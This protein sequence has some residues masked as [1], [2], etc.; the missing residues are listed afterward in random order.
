MGEGW[1]ESRTTG[2]V[3]Y[4]ALEVLESFH[5]R[6]GNNG[7]GFGLSLSTSSSAS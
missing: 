2:E 3:S 5:L 1:L 7:D 4:E 6:T